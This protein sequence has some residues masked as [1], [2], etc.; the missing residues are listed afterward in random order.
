[1]IVEKSPKARIGDLDKKKY[2]VPSGDDPA[3]YF[4]FFIFFTC[5]SFCASFVV[6]T[7]NFC[8]FCVVPYSGDF[9]VTTAPTH[10]L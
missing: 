2:L 4:L 10:M 3:F 1:V 6:S 9:F 8:C 7:P 5:I